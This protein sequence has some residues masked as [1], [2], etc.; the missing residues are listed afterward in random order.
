MDTDKFS[1]A[2]ILFK[3]FMRGNPVEGAKVHAACVL[4]GAKE[5]EFFGTNPVF[6]FDPKDESNRPVKGVDNN[7]LKFW[8]LYPEYIRKLFLR[9]FTDGLHDPSKR[10]IDNEWMNALIRLRSEIVRCPCGRN[11]IFM[12]YSGLDGHSFTCPKCG[13]RIHVLNVNGND[14]PLTAG[15]RIFA[16]QT[17]YD[18]EDCKTVTAEVVENKLHPGI[19]CIRNLSDAPWVITYAGGTVKNV[20][21]GDTTG[22]DFGMIIDFGKGIKGKTE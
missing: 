11:P 2:V 16:N 15:I 9:A 8:G 5:L 19:L 20:K 4:T 12:S 18:S 13:R 6:I 22:I 10:P 17:M 1:L 21:K 7:V 3:L 14:I